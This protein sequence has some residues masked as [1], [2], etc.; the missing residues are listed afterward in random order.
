MNA[1]QLAT[2]AGVTLA[3]L[4]ASAGA[5]SRATDTQVDQ[6]V[7]SNLA[8]TYKIH[9]EIVSHIDLTVPFGTKSR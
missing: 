6:A 4:A 5:D 3:F 1:R 8:S 7:L 2:A 9:S